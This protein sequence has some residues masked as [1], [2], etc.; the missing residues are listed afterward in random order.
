[1]RTQ[2]T[3]WVYRDDRPGYNGRAD[4]CY[5]WPEVVNEPTNRFD[6]VGC[7]YVKLFKATYGFTPRKNRWT[8]FI[9]LQGN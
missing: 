5:V 8:E 7:Y 9:I 3:R 2:V 6:S 1:M 4:D